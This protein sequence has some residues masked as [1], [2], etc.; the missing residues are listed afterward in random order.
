MWLWPFYCLPWSFS[1]AF[2]SGGFQHFPVDG[3]SA[4]SCNFGALAEDERTCSFIPSLDSICKP[5]HVIF[6]FHLV[7]SVWQFLGPSILLQITFFKWLY[8]TFNVYVYHIF[9]IHS[10]VDG[11]WVCFHVLA[12]VNSASVNT[13]VYVSFE[14]IVFRYITR[15]RMGGSHGSSI[16]G[17][18]RNFHTILHSGCIDF[19]SSQQ[20]KRFPFSPHLLQHLLFANFFWWWPFWPVWGDTSL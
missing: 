1:F 8:S 20:C 16:F 4:A 14:M 17:S 18:L 13:G 7:Y 3:C 15:S 9:F 12:N 2:G 5:Y 6:V 19:H 11:H 10:S